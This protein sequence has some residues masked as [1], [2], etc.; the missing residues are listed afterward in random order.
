MDVYNWSDDLPIHR[1]ATTV[2]KK[3]EIIHSNLVL[4]SA[5]SHALKDIERNA[6]IADCVW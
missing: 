3:Y 1:S 5:M 4:W 6:G 2:M